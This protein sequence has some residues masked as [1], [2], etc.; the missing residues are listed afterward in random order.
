MRRIYLDNNATT[1]L[2]PQVLEAMLPWLNN[3]PVNP[4]STHSFGQEAKGALSKA[5]S[6]VAEAL[7]VKPSEI[8]FTSGGTE[9][10]NFLL[11][12]FFAAHPQAHVLTSNV[13]HSCVY[14]TLQDLEKKG[15]KVTFLPVGLFG[16][17]CAEDVKQA[18]KPETKLICL[19]SVNNVTG[20][21]TDIASIAKLA[22]ER[23][24][25]FIVDGVSHLGKEPLHIPSGVSAMGFS[26]HK[27]HGPLG[28]GCVFIRSNFKIS[29]LLTG[30]EQEFSRRGGTQNLPAIVGFAKAVE[31]LKTVLPEATVKM[32]K[33][34]NLLIEELSVKVG[35]I[36]VHAQAPLICNTAQISFPG[37]DGETL[38][39][40]LDLAGIAVSHGSACS[41]GGLEP[42][43]VLLN[44]GIAPRIARSSLR[45]SLSRLTTEEEIHKTVEAIQNIIKY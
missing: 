32:E 8:I 19:M 3:L 26:G 45:F 41:S 23:G 20:A 39:M 9:S 36:V 33:L 17:V 22:E 44:M 27:L 43:H 31:L 2:D 21:K 18:I 42:S 35:P 40:Q 11:R 34:K 29:P 4:S 37:M 14:K 6:T 13:E 1:A 24:I 16:A 15:A 10:M 5:R 30:G 7:H 38:L 28:S 12:G 25:A